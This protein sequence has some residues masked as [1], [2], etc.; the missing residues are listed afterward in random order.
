M[1]FRR[2]LL[3]LAALVSLWLGSSNAAALEL[4]DLAERTKPSVVHITVLNSAG[5][6]AGSG[7]GF[8]VA[9]GGR[10]ATNDH[11]VASAAS[12][13][14]TLSDG[15]EVEV[16]G[17]LSNDAEKDIA[18]IQLAG[19]D[20]PP[21]LDL[22]GSGALRQGEEVV[23]IGSPRG[24]SGTLSTG[25]I[26]A[27][28]GEGLDGGTAEERSLRAWAIQITA[29]ISPGSSGSPIMTRDG[30]VVAVAVGIMR[31][32]GSLNFGVPIEVV[33]DMLSA[34]PP[35]AEPSAFVG[36]GGVVGPGAGVSGNLIVSAIFF[37]AVALAFV[38]GSF[39][40]KRRK[41]PKR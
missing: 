31:G 21:A 3:M 36:S 9:D 2:A 41:R 39:L 35:D 34:L 1:H 13:K 4:P 5:D 27:I 16:L 26:S 40:A 37:G 20:F 28:R 19:T 24:L 15:R 22:G 18:I 38:V 33:K 12:V 11:V 10:V 23:V 30:K 14:A 32:E 6:K 17:V 7:T 8:V 25:I 29:P